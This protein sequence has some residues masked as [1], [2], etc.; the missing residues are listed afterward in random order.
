MQGNVQGALIGI[1]CL[2]S[3]LGSPAFAYVFA[4]CTKQASKLPYY[5]GELSNSYVQYLYIQVNWIQISS[6]LQLAWGD[7][8]NV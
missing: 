4:L 8:H 6:T 3:G 5:P 2:T 7:Q 1:A